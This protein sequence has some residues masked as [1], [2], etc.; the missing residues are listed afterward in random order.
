MVNQTWTLLKESISSFLQDEA[1]TR[2][3]AI[4]FY[5]VTSIGPVLFIIVAI[6]GLVFGEEAASGA[7]SA[8]LGGLMGQQSAELLQTAIQNASGKLSGSLATLLGV[9]VLIITASGVFT[10]MQQT[11][12]VIWKAEPQGSTVSA[13]LRARATSLGLVA[14]L[15]FLLLVSLVISTILTALSNFINA[16][17]PAGHLILQT[18]N[19]LA[20][21][22]L[23]TVLFA[24]IYKM[25]PDRRIEWRDVVVGA[26]ATSLL[27]T[28]GKF[29]IGLYL[30]SSTVATSYGAAGGLIIV[31]LWVYYSAQIFL[32]GAE[33]TK[34][35][36][37]HHGSR[38]RQ[39]VS[40][41]VS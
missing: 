14:A 4:A 30:G 28:I 1:L 10:E 40:A 21:F 3:A 29:L 20:S 12:N 36:A 16:M 41:G 17:L 24:A 25:V 38:T 26:V 33:F 13:L 19:F 6:A 2:G 27:F 23:I 15:G 5:T 8:Q 9:I 34:A 32:F 22:V 37:H 39:A 7:V 18:L 31:L 35:Y 11:L